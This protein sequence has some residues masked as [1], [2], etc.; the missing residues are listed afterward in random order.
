MIKASWNTT[1]AYDFSEEFP[2]PVTLAEAE[3][4][5]LSLRQDLNKI[6]Q[7]LNDND[8]QA[9]MGMTGEEY[10]RWRHKATHARN[11]KSVQQQKLTYWI[12]QVRAQRAVESLSTKDPAIILAEIVDMMSDLRQKHRIPLTP[13][14]QNIMSLAQHVVDHMDA[15]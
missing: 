14:Q 15:R 12:D 13:E 2:E 11:V 10:Q 5:S 4:R 1:S 9:K 6:R 3:E 8:R 7:Q